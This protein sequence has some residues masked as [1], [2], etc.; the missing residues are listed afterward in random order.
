MIRRDKRWEPLNALAGSAER[1]QAARMVESERKLGEAEQRLQDL[2]RYRLEYEQSFA[3]R[4]RAG[5]DMRGLR[6]HQV[7]IARLGE[8]ARAQQQ[9]IAQLRGECEATRLGWREAATHKKV[10]GKVMEKAR[11]EDL[12]DQDRAAQHEVDERAARARV[13]Q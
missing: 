9:L 2:V 4:A 10:V 13:P 1:S 11:A 12:L 6:E 3:A 7:F 8:A 5:A